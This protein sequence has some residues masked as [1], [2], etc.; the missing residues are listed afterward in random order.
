MHQCTSVV[1]EITTVSPDLVA[2]SRRTH[3]KWKSHHQEKCE[4]L[5]RHSSNIAS[6]FERNWQLALPVGT[7]HYPPSFDMAN[8]RSTGVAGKLMTCKGAI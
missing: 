6:N 4:Y 7:V 5:H 2:G 8:V 1:D 3:R